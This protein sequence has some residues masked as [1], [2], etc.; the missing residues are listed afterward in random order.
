MNKIQNKKVITRFPPSPTGTV[1]VGSLRTALFNYIFAKKYNG[2]MILR[3]EDTDSDRNK[4]GSEEGMRKALDWLGLKYTGGTRQSERTGIYK[5]Y[6]ERMISDGTVYVSNEEG[7]ARKSVIRFKNPNK[8]V[9]FEDQIRGKI[10]VDTTDL[11][12]FVVA[13]SLE[14]P[15]YHLSVVV[16]DIEMEVTHVIR[17]EDGLSNTPR[18]IYLPIYLFFP[19]YC[20]THV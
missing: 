5:R 20:P 1:H 10:E 7:G 2:V 9:S 16:D 15:L 11:K 13:K 4:E 12:D 18:Q 8:K 17:G 14:E 3:F 19:V 6:L